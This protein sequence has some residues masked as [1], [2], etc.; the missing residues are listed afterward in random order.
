MVSTE[1][2]S[3]H[4]G[5]VVSPLLMLSALAKWLPLVEVRI[6]ILLFDFISGHVLV[7]LDLRPDESLLEASFA[8]EVR[9]CW[10]M[11]PPCHSLSRMSWA[12]QN[13]KDNCSF[14]LF[15]KWS[16]SHKAR[17]VPDNFSLTVRLWTST[18]TPK[19]SR[20]IANWHCGGL[21]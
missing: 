13:L 6:L 2:T 20:T 5:M 15:S 21:L 14:P 19:E 11:L 4:P 17:A 1:R 7:V 9:L 3:M 8:R 16:L 12:V 10:N 18:K